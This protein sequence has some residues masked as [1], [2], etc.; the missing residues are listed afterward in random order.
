MM[1]V[2]RFVEIIQITHQ[3]SACGHP[4]TPLKRLPCT[5]KLFSRMCFAPEGLSVCSKPL[6]FMDNAQYGL[7]DVVL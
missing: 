6:N 2:K 1:A 3:T 5:D 7:S 4:L